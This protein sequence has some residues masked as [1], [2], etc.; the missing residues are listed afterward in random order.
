MEEEGFEGD[1]K[2]IISTSTDDTIDVLETTL[3]NYR[4]SERQVAEGIINY[5]NTIGATL[6][7]KIN[8]LIKRYIG[9]E[10]KSIIPTEINI[11]PCYDKIAKTIDTKVTTSSK[12]TTVTNV[13]FIQHISSL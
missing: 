3:K 11:Q 10:D 5:A 1:L 12:S 2:G 13:C 4:Y 6:D 7:D 9:K 8:D